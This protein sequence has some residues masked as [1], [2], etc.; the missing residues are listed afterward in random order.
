MH[1]QHAMAIFPVAMPASSRW[2]VRAEIRKTY[3]PGV[4]C[5]PSSS[6][7]SQFSPASPAPPTL[8]R[9]VRTTR[10]ESVCSLSC[11]ALHP[12]NESACTWKRATSLTPSPFGLNGLGPNAARRP[13][14]LAAPA[15]STAS[16]PFSPDRDASPASARCLIAPDSVSDQSQ[17]GNAVNL[18]TT[19]VSNL[20]SIARPCP[21]GN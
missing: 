10:P 4:H 19:G 13:A 5:L 7:R 21:G 12:R 20:S 9:M 14:G 8:G 17:L 6:R 1:P 15:A 11:N 18:W 16:D 2:D 3:S